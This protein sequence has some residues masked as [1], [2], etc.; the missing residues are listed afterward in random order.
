MNRSHRVWLALSLGAAVAC[1]GM[2]ADAGMDPAVEKK[3]V[4]AWFQGRIERLT[5]ETGWLTL[6]GLFPIDNGTYTFG[7]AEDNDLVFPGQ[8]PAHAGRLTVTDG[9]VHLDVLDGV[10]MTHDG[11]PFTSIDMAGDGSGDP[12]EVRMGTYDFYVIDRPGSRYL[13][14]KDS[15]SA[16]RRSFAGIERYPVDVKW[17]VAARLDPYDPPRRITVPNVMG[18]DE[19]VDCRGA[20]VFQ[21]EGKEYRLEPMSEGDGEMFIVFGDA[22]SGHETYGGGRF[23]YIKSPDEKGN[24]YIDFNRAYNPP[25]VFTPYATCPLPHA[26]NILPFKVEAGEKAYEHAAQHGRP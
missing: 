7:G 20:L 11:T 15:E 12:T 26:D 5:S 1:G 24:T 10:T 4:E 6:V 2:S 17:R 21:W 14:V 19:V 16:V 9:G 23:V 18:F 25:C 8:A 3:D 22:T 13:R